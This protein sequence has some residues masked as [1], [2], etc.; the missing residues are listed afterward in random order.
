MTTPPASNGFGYDNYAK[1]IEGAAQGAGSAIQGA[2]RAAQT[3][4]EAKEVKRQTLANLLNKALRRQFGLYRAQGEYD[5]DVTMD[6]NQN[7]Q[8]IARGFVDAFR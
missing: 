4:R 3:K 1:V 7:L 6:Q 8:Q 2:N 5:D